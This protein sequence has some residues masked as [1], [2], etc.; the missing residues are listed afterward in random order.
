MDLDDVRNAKS[1]TVS[2]YIQKDGTRDEMARKFD[3]V[4][5]QKKGPRK[6]IKG[7]PRKD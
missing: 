6:K 4:G 5:R 3:R 7:R 2:P 1:S